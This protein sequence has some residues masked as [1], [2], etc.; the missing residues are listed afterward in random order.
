MASNLFRSVS[1]IHKDFLNSVNSSLDLLAPP[2]T[3]TSVLKGDYIELPPVRESKNG[4]VEFK[5]PPSERYVDLSQS[6]MTVT[7]RVVTGAGPN[8]SNTNAN[9]KVL[10]ISY[11]LHSLFQTMLLSL[12]QKEVE[13]E[14]NYPYRSYMEGLLNFGN[15]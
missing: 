8:L 4:V 3:G 15:D 7:A 12:N 1:R 14:G 13:F 10:P 9:V 6:F 2:H 5:F 11:M